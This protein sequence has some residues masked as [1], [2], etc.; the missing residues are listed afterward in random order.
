MIVVDTNVVAYLLLQ[1]ERTTEAE[2]AYRRDSDWIAPLLWRS[3]FRNILVNYIRR[4]EL[5]LGRALQLAERAEK[6]LRGREHV[7]L[8]LDVLSLAAGSSRSA[9]DCEFVALAEQSG[10]P[11]VTADRGIVRDFPSTAIALEAFAANKSAAAG[12]KKP[13]PPKG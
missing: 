4:G 8:S 11:L 9:Y 1:G 3:E 6:L 7:V 10:I 13:P 5:A 12:G 2:R